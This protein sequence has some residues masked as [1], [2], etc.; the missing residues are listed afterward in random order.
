MSSSIYSAP[1]YKRL[2]LLSCA[3]TRSLGFP[4]STT[5]PLSST[6]TVSKSKR[7]PKRCATIMIVCFAKSSLIISCIL[8]SVLVSTLLVGSSS[9]KTLLFLKSALA[10]QN[11]CFCP[12]ERK[13]TSMTTSRAAAP[14][15]PSFKE[16][17][18]QRETRRSAE[19]ISASVASRRGSAFRQMVPVKRNGSC[20][21]QVIF[22]RIRLRGM[23]DKSWESRIM[24]PEL[25][26]RRRRIDKMNE[27]FPLLYC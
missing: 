23:V 15:L 8:A 12:M 13:F 27:L 3:S 24:R 22:W 11:S 21:R 7:L 20:V 17:V 6:T 16:I 5:T 26:S 18:S 19:I 10:R 14:A 25:R 1:W 9:I 2:N 4:F